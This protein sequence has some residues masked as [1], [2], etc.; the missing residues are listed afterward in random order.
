MRQSGTNHPGSIYFTIEAGSERSGGVVDRTGADVAAWVADFLRNAAHA[1]VLG[2]LA[3]SG[4]SERHAFII[5]PAFSTGPN[6]PRDAQ[7]ARPDVGPD[8]L[9][10]LV[11]G[12][13]VDPVTY[14]FSG[15]RS[16]N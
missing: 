7:Q 14:R 3:R 13:G 15:D 5:V 11:V 10:N 8:L 6:L 4:A 9:N 16:A 2:K 1:D 12:T